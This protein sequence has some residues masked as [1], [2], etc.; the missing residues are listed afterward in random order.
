[1]IGVSE[2][3]TSVL[4]KL[5]RGKMSATE[6][7]LQ[8]LDR[9]DRINPTVNALVAMR[10]ANELLA[11]AQV[12]DQGP[13]TR[14][15]HGLPIAIKDLVN[16]AGIRSTQGSKLFADHVPTADD[17]IVARLRAA[18]AIIVGKTNTPEFGLGSHTFN[19]VYGVTKN[20]YD[21]SVTCGG[22]SGGA[23]V[24]VATGMLMLADGSDMMGSLR[25]PAGWNNVY[26]LRPTWGLVP[27]Q[28]DGDI[29]LHQLATSGPI[30]R[31]PDDISLLLDVMA[32]PDPYQP[33]GGIQ[34][35]KVPEIGETLK[36]IRLA[37]LGD[38]DGQ[39]PLEE[40]ILTV[41]HNALGAFER[42]GARID[43]LVPPFDAEDM[44]QSW[45]V[46]R[47]WQVGVKLEPY[48]HRKDQ[49]KATAI[50]EFEK[51]QA[52]SAFDVHAASCIRSHWFRTATELLNE[53]D[54]LVLPTA[55]VWP[56]ETT[57]EYPPRIGEITMD[58]YHRWMHVMVPASLAGLPALAVPAGFSN[59]G[60]PMGI[61]LIGRR[62]ADRHLIAIARRYHAFTNWPGRH[63]PTLEE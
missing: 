1:M 27:N 4:G 9:I 29:F 25:N 38:W 34:A 17:A 55:Q 13:K 8:T 41:C 37:W 32:T 23:A 52:L 11:E 10:D 28:P 14:S 57:F 15:L 54:A 42:L 63:P 7:M 22:S 30:A 20:P 35:A 46:L 47:S 33:H 21:H 19:T 12:V 3:A 50:W 62:G 43:N 51:A 56:F 26:G 61:Q 39:F 18:G 58:T 40:G 31:N 6:L 5:K 49:I 24:A 44:F 45:V 59:A 48:I 53:Y 2:S 16:V 36:N 60:L